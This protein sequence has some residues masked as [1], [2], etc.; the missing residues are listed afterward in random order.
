MKQ[1]KPNTYMT[2]QDYQNKQ[3]TFSVGQRVTHVTDEG[4]MCSATVR[5]LVLPDALELVFDDGDEGTENCSTC[6]VG[7]VE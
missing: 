5:E 7:V 3:T 2:T 6:F 4:Q 1:L